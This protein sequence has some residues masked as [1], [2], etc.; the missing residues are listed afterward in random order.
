M[1]TRYVETKVDSLVMELTGRQASVLAYVLVRAQED[2]EFFDALT[3]SSPD[4][5]SANYLRGTLDQ[6]IK[7][8]PR[9][10]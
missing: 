10:V 4:P 6:L 5:H 3:G 9:A 7:K 2:R 8:V 1:T